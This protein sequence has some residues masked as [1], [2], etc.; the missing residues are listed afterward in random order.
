MMS[1]G[2]GKRI[3]GRDVVEQAKLVE[4]LFGMAA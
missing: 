4:S 1:K 3:E 2:Q